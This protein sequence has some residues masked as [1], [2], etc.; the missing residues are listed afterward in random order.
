LPDDIQDFYEQ[1]YG[2]TANAETLRWLRCELMQ[3]VWEHLLND[4]EFK[5]AYRHGIL[6]KCADGILRRLFPRFFTY[7]ADY[8]EKV[9]LAAMR[10][11][12]E[13]PCP[14][15]LIK[16][17]QVSAAGMKIDYQRRVHKRKDN[18]P[19]QLT[20]QRVRQWIFQ[21][22]NMASKAVLKTLK[23]RSLFPVQVSQTTI[24]HALT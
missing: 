3:R 13:C 10:H 8:P 21:G 9:L 5:E 6:V 2:G 22:K 4:E 15:C 18:R 16:M 14:R 1:H 20:I 12:A 23:D 17:K 24:V 19:L 7:A 11:L